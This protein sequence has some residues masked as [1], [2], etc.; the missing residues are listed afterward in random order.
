M[1]ELR[2]SLLRLDEKLGNVPTVEMIESAFKG[3]TFKFVDLIR[4]ENINSS[5]NWLNSENTMTIELRHPS[6]SQMAKLTVAI[7][8]LKPNVIDYM[9]ATGDCCV[10]YWLKWEV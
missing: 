7:S 10:V 9:N 2:P 5:S 1:V 3:I 8:S 6:T 4:C